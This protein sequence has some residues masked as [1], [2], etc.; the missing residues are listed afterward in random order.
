M[1]GEGEEEGDRNGGGGGRREWVHE[2]VGEAYI[3]YIDNGG[4]KWMGE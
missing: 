1:E 4:S 3:H 2:W